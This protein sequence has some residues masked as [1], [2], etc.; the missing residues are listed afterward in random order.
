MIAPHQ[1]PLNPYSSMIL[2]QHG[3]HLQQPP[4]PLTDLAKQSEPLAP[5]VSQN[6]RGQSHTV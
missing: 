3:A 4:L 2:I 5:A 6:L 1:P